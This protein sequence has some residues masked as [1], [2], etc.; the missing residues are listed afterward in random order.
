MSAGEWALLMVLAVVWG[1]SF[2]MA[3]VAL[4]DFRPFTLVLCRVALGAAALHLVVLAN[5]MRMPGSPRVW[6]RFLIIGGLNNLIPFS[7]IFWG[8]TQIASGL[9]AILTATTPIFT[10]LLAHGVTK[11]ERITRHRLLGLLAGLLGVA[12]LIGPDALRGPG[13]G[14]LAQL[15]VLAAGLSY[16]IGGVYGRHFRDTPPLITATGQVTATTLM[17]IPI[18]L[19]T[20]RPW[21][22]LPP[23]T[24]AVL[25]MVG[26]A[27]LSTAFAQVIY[28]R[29]LATAGPTNVVLVTFLIPVTATFLGIGVLGEQMEARHFAGLGTILL[30]LA[31]TDGR[32]LTRVEGSMGRRPEP[33]P[34]AE[35]SP[36]DPAPG[37][38]ASA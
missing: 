18:V 10:V 1:S 31:A 9:A 38:P 13:V 28:F 21:T 32:L 34:G 17:M 36:P 23:G 35:P 8:Q 26:L 12:V 30:G 37:D 24:S 20:D 16:A 25:A 3:R 6:G 4:D 7:L 5:G 27:L 22:S 33:G 14:V 11:D 2:S 15:A 29:L 19:V